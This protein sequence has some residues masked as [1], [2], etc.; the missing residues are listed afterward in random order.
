MGMGVAMVIVMVV[1]TVL[2]GGAIAW[3]ALTRLRSRVRRTG[4]PA[5]PR[6]PPPGQHHSPGDVSTDR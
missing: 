3:G 1:M 6:Q 4:S 5:E 2:M